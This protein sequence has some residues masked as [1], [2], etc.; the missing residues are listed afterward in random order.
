MAVCATPSAAVG[1]SMITS[2]EFHSTALAMATA[3]RCPPESDATGWRMDRTV[4]TESPA[5]VSVA[6]FSM[7]FSSS[8][9]ALVRS[10]PRNMFCTMS[11]LSAS[12]RS[13]YTVWIPS[14]AASRGVRMR[15]GRP[16]Q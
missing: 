5:R 11:R 12:A 14:A 10:R 2:C 6:D 13:W 8:R 15:T 16:S 1:S 4:V 7:L 9:S 3:W